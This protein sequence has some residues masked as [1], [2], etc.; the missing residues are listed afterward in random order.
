MGFLLQRAFKCKQ[1]SKICLE[2][3]SSELSRLVNIIKYIEVLFPLLFSV[4]DHDNRT[5]SNKRKSHLHTAVLHLGSD[6]PSTARL[7][8]PSD[9]YTSH[10]YY[11][12]TYTSEY[13]NNDIHVGA[14]RAC[15]HGLPYVYL[16]WYGGV[17]L[18]HSSDITAAL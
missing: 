16:R 1:Y 2:S 4:A 3:L 13:V 17:N 11:A 7:L 18:Q 6:A 10:V 15:L 12:Y 9:V 14:V 8:N 5:N